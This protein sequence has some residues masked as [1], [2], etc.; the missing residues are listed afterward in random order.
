MQAVNT[1]PQDSTLNCSSTVVTVY[2]PVIHRGTFGGATSCRGVLRTLLQLHKVSRRNVRVCIRSFTV[3][4]QS[5]VIK[6]C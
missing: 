2:T 1:F 4:F 3:C 5:I 6:L